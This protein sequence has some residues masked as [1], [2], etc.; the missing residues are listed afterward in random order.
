M[1]EPEVETRPWAEQLAVDDASYRTQL[2]YLLERSPFYRKKLDGF[3]TG[4]LAEIAQLPLTEKDEL[5]QTRTPESPFGAHLCAEPVIQ[6]SR[7]PA[8]SGM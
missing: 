6:L 2:A 4:G 5:R 1:L 3:E 8:V 7:S